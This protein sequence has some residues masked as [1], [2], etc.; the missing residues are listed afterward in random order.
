[1]NE[2]EKNISTITTQRDLDLQQNGYLLSFEFLF[3]KEYLF[4]KT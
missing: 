3:V 4:H 1:M 2:I